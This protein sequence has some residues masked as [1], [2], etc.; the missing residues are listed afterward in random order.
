METDLYQY[1]IGGAPEQAQI[2]AIVDQL[3]RRR[4]LGELGMLT[5]DRVLSPFGQGMVKQADAYAGSLQ[6]VRQKDADNAQTKAYQDAQIK[7]QEGVLNATLGRDRQNAA[8]QLRADEADLL[9]AQAAM[10]RAKKAG[11]TV[12]KTLPTAGIKDLNESKLQLDK[13]QNLIDTFKPEYARMATPGART[14]ANSLAKVGIGTEKTKDAQNW[15]RQYDLD[16]TLPVR[17]KTFGATLSANEQKAWSDAAAGKEM[18]ADQITTILD[19]LKRW[20][21]SDLARKANT[22]KQ[23]YNPAMV[24]A[25]IGQEHQPEG[26]EPTDDDF[27]D[28]WAAY[29]KNPKEAD[30]LWGMAWPNHPAP[31][32]YSAEAAR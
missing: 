6:D 12:L 29:D 32:S 8:H 1:L 15:W 26:D 9:R 18:T 10:E 21:Q 25:A 24:D 27:S 22:Y 2:P 3:R 5:G 23:G 28:Y 11:G 20:Q 19:S 17:N 14:L 30:R 4:S 16:Y 7:Y 31:A 13:T